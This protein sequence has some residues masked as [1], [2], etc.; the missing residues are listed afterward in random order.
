MKI[1]FTFGGMPHYLNALLR[2]IQQKDGIEVC[3]VI[4]E[5]NGKSIGKGVKQVEDANDIKTF[6]LTEYITFSKKPFFKGFLKVLKAEKPDILV[7]G[8]PYIVPLSL[9]LWLLFYIKRNRIGLVFREIPFNVAPYDKVFSYFKL[10][11]QY[12]E[13]MNII[14]P[15]GL[16]FYLWAFLIKYLLKWY[17]S[18]IDAS[19]AYAE[20]AYEIHQSY[21]LKEKQIFVTCNSPDTEILA[22][23]Q[24]KII[25]DR[26]ELNYNPQRLLHIGRLVKW[27]RVDLLIEVTARLLSK[28]PQTELLIIGTGPEE[29]TLRNQA[30]RLG[31]AQ[32]VTFAGSI[33]E[34]DLAKYIM[35]SGIY[36][37]AGM[38]GLSINEAMSFGK[39]VICSV[40]DGT[41]KTLVRDGYNGLFFE[42]GSVESLYQKID[43]LFENQELIT[44]MGKNSEKII[45]NEVNLDTVSDKFLQCFEYVY[46]LKRK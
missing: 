22:G 24:R 2:K 37:L 31:I 19:L 4:P 27:K 8:W 1:L 10:N 43:Y 12:D 39:P 23:A 41:E 46:Q 32:K 42:N 44:T 35:S 9:N 11:P 38:G 16:K 21:G 25:A 20:S 26:V 18:L 36:V 17:Y 5:S 7:I 28:H 34:E 45:Q 3:V 30:E 14:T 29:K 13:D 40:C 6:K 15:R 33:Y